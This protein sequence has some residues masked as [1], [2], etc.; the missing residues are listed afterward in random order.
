MRRQKTIID[1]RVRLLVTTIVRVVVQGTTPQGLLAG[2]FD[3][4]PSRSQP[5]ESQSQ[6]QRRDQQGLPASQGLPKRVLVVDD[7]SLIADSVATILNR[8]GYQAIARY[9]GQ[10]ALQSVQEVCPDIV[11]SDVVMPDL[12]GIQLAKAVRSMCPLTRIVLFSGNVDTESLLEE[13][14][15]EGYFFEIL[16][17]P[18]HPLHLLKTLK[19]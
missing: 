17:K 2:N 5:R 7:E 19:S 13:A 6:S 4:E 9:N 18:V 16:T 15:M 12:N 3:G 11:V 14:T 8:S 10:D 1:R